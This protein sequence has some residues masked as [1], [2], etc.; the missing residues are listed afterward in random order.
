MMANDYEIPCN[1][2]SIRKLQVNA[3][4]ESLHQTI[5]NIK[6]IYKIQE[7]NLGNENP[8]EGVLSSTMFAIRSTVHI[9]L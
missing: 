8:W 7:I 5:D 3:I 2:I 4:V 9:T 1:S 6:R